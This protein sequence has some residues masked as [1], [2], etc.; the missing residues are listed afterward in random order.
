M[1]TKKYDFVYQYVC[2]YVYVSVCV[3]EC[4]NENIMRISPWGQSVSINLMIYCGWEKACHLEEINLQV[5][6]TLWVFVMLLIILC[7]IANGDKLLSSNHFIRKTLT[8]QLREFKGKIHRLDAM[9]A[10]TM[11]TLGLIKQKNVNKV[12]STCIIV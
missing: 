9:K 1:L 4:E 2:V 10:L 12:M 3:W 5:I 11:K 6:L 8:L 7:W